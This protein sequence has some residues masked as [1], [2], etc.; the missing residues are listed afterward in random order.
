ARWLP[1]FPHGDSIR[2]V[3]LLQHASGIPHETIPDS[4]MTRPFTTA[5]VAARAAAL[6]LDFTPGTRSSYS[7]GGYEVLAPVLE[8]AS[9][10]PS[11]R[12]PEERL[13]APL[14]MT[15]SAHADSR[16]LLPGRACA[17][18]PGPHGIE[19]APLQDLSALVGAGSVWSTARDLH[20]FVAAVRAGRL[21][22]G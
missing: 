18:V 14:G 16:A 20:R 13:F 2:V 19:N 21:G 6:P 8:L 15:H 12:R 9:G 17:Y 4:V 22:P 11:P 7:S 5:E 3:H 1:A 10:R